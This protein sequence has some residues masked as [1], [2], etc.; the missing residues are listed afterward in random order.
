MAQEEEYRQVGVPWED[1]YQ[2]EY[3]PSQPEGARKNAQILKEQGIKWPPEHA[4]TT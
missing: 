4:K 2:A 1:E 3:D